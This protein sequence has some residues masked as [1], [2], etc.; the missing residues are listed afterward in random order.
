[1]L[2]EST[3]RFT[4]L[5]KDYAMIIHSKDCGRDWLSEIAAEVEA[6]QQWS[7]HY[8]TLKWAKA[9]ATNVAFMRTK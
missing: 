4:I 1:M 6:E 7:A 9:T 3:T 5:R 2:P 8:A